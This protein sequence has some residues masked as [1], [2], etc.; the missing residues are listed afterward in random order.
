[1]T[2]TEGNPTGGKS[3][4]EFAPIRSLLFAHKYIGSWHLNIIGARTN[5]ITFYFVLDTPNTYR[6]IEFC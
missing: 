6:Y 3:V 4:W 2:V 1:M 5:I